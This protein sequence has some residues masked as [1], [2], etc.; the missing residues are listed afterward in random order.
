[1]AGHLPGRDAPVGFGDAWVL[2]VDF[3][4]PG[5]ALSVLAYGQTTNADSPHSRDQLRLFAEHK[6]R[7]ALY[8]EEDIKANT[9]RAYHPR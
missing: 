9:S 5:S 7:P 1:M 3:S 4:R 2:L 6:L 8:R